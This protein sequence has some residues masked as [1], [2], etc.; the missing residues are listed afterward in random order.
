MRKFYSLS[1]AAMLIF[2]FNSALSQDSTK[3]TTLQEV[4]VSASRTEQP[5]IEI[6]RSVTVIT[7]EEIRNSVH[8]SLGDLLNAQSGLYVVGANQTPG[9]NQNLF[10]R[11]SNSN[12]VAVLVDG[13]R[14]TDAS[15]PNAA[16]DLSEISLANV[17]RI[18]VIRGSHS[19]IFG[20]AAVGGVIN[21]ITKGNSAEGFH[22]DVSWQ[23]GIM[24]KPSWSS[25]ENLNLTYRLRNGLYFAGSVFQQDVKGL[26]SAE[27]SGF[28]PSFTSDRDDFRKTDASFK[29]GFRNE[30]WDAGVSFKNVHQYT[31]IDDGAFSDDDNNYLVFD[32][33]L[34]QHS[35][36]YKI[37][38]YLR[39]M[40]L[41]SFSDS[42]RF[43]EDDSSR[44]SPTTWDKTFSTGTYFG[45]LQT[46]E[47]QL[48]YKKKNAQGVVGAG[49][50]RE[51][52]HFENY[53]YYNDP[54]FSFES[55]VNY[56]SLNPRTTT[57]YVYAQLVYAIGNVSMTGGARLSRHTTAG[58]FLT[59][60]LNPSYTFGELLLF[61]SLST[62]FNA[63]SLYQLYDPSKNFSAYTTRGNPALEP[64]RSLSIEVGI[65]KQFYSGSYLT[66]S[67]YHTRVRNSIEYIYL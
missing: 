55:E 43:Y 8:Q 33:K 38:P 66:A 46:H 9:T 24:D 15:S 6:P 48:N 18:E 45:N 59:F 13:V 23:V 34:L 16:I 12:Q 44:V 49:L 4:V 32:R 54:A 31:E 27:P 60:E 1:L 64:E 41:S 10:M 22:G 19:T 11:G 42:E 7:A 36:E 65:K 17:E 5:L 67:A 62:G 25:T 51:K 29:A 50:Y 39:V 3:V 47:V 57:G 53:F 35:V 52:M 58:N 14:I 2:N 37:D 21:L 26:N 30:N 28:S 20:G 61:G 56:D 63:P 40:L